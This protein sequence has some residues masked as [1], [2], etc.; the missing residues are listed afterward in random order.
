MRSSAINGF[1]ARL[2]A[3]IRV[4]DWMDRRYQS[5]RASKMT[6]NYTKS[7]EFGREKVGTVYCQRDTR[8]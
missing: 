6:W 5:S 8:I 1:A 7:N 4:V 2:R 3:F